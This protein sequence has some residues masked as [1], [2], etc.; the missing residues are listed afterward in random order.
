MR[1]VNSTILCMN[2]QHHAVHQT[3][4]KSLERFET[5]MGTCK[6]NIVFYCGQN[7]Q[8]IIMTGV[9]TFS[10]YFSQFPYKGN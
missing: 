4:H 8:I 9:A 5:S 7:W 2:T 3:S 10:A 1:V 6:R